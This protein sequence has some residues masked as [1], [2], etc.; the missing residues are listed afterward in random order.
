VSG[1][2]G[3]TLEAVLERDRRARRAAADCAAA[4]IGNAA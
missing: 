4:L 3:D 1:G 2:S